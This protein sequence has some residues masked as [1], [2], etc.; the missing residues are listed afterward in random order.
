L[1]D[2]IYQRQ[3][4][5]LGMG[6]VYVLKFAHW[7]TLPDIAP[8]AAA[9]A[10]P[11]TGIAG[12]SHHARDDARAEGGDPDALDAA[13]E[14]T[15]SLTRLELPE[16]CRALGRNEL[17]PLGLVLQRAGRGALWKNHQVLAYAL[18]RPDDATLHILIYDPNY[19]GDDRCII[20]VEGLGIGAS[21]LDPEQDAALIA[22][23]KPGTPA[24]T[25]EMVRMIRLPTRGTPRPVRGL[26]PMPY[27]MVKP[28]GA[29]PGNDSPA[30][31]DGAARRQDEPAG[32]QDEGAGLSSPARL[33][34]GL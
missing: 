3:R 25:G 30:P 6:S 15:S 2:S 1:Y 32:L 22:G 23:L 33:R 19:P 13:P 11:A 20:R 16:V 10:A 21:G 27:E 34:P 29:A 24:T 17:V 8:P 12:V 26:F 5:S 28:G 14:S 31:R 9:S 7:M 18:E 4:D